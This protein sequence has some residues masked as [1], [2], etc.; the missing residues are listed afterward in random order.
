MNLRG[1]VLCACVVM[2]ASAVSAEQPE[3]PQPTAEHERLALWVG[4]WHG[5]GDTWIFLSSEHMGGQEYLT[6]AT[7]TMTSPKTIDV[8]WEMSED[9]ESWMLLMEGTSTKK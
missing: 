9:G 6:R 2:M 8:S 4:S 3:M 1:T 7:M 5:E